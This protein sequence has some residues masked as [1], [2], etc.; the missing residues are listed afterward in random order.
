[1]KPTKKSLDLIIAMGKPSSKDDMAPAGIC[2]KCGHDCSG[3][4]EEEDY[5]DEDA[6]D[7]SAPVEK[8]ENYD[9]QSLALAKAI[10]AILQKSKD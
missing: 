3:D 8:D 5:D 4:E 10:A 2:P 1:M 7:E 6:E 9:K